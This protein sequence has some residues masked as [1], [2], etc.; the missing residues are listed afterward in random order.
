MR[1]KTDAAMTAG[2]ARPS[3]PRQPSNVPTFDAWPEVQQSTCLPSIVRSTPSISV[4][5]LSLA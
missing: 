5:P 1:D 4:M 3:Q 2:W